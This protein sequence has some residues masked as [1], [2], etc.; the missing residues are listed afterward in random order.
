MPV[1]PEPAA[2]SFTR[3]MLRP[4]SGREVILVVPEMSSRVKLSGKP[5]TGP[6]VPQFVNLSACR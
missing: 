5:G 4:S 1:S 2:Y 6:D 3:F